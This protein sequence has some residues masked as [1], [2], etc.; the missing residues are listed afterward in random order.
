MLIQL[1]ELCPNSGG[2]FKITDAGRWVHMV[3]SLYVAEVTFADVERYR[4]PSLANIGF[5]KWGSK[6]CSLCEDERYSLTGVCVSCDAG[7]CKTY[8]H[9]TCAQREG[10]L[11]ARAHDEVDPHIVHCKL[12]SDRNAA[13]IKRRNYLALVAKHRL[14][15]NTKN[16]Q[17]SLS[18]EDCI[19]NQRTLSKLFSQRKKF[20]KN[21]P[22]LEHPTNCELVSFT[23][24]LLI[25][26]CLQPT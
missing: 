11:C 14:L 9:V 18:I 19:T 13:K 7:M 3:C 20:T 12:H 25:N 10:L 22:E 6:S 1:C 15:A 8:F 2:I 16:Q 23:L 24:L 5:N 17:N 26:L 4:G 21:F